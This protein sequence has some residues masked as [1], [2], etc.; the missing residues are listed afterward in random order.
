MAAIV[1]HLRRNGAQSRRQLSDALHLSWGCV[2]ELVF[3]LTSRGVL[4]EETADPGAKGRTPG[5]LALNP[6]FCFLGVEITLKTIRGCV[7][8][9]LGRKVCSYE[10]PSEHGAK[11]ALISCVKTFV[12]GIL[13]THPS[14]QGIGFAMQGIQLG[15]VWEFPSSPRILLSF[16]AD[17][18]PLF[19]LPS[20]M[21]H[22]PNCI[23]YSCLEGTQNRTMVLRLNHGIGATVH[24]PQGFLRDALLELGYYVVNDRGT[25]MQQVA[26]LEALQKVCGEVDPHAP[27]AE[28]RAFLEDMGR[29]VG[30]ALGNLC[31]LL[32]LDEILLCGGMTAYYHLF[33]PTLL[34]HY[35]K[36][37]LPLTR[38]QIIALPVT[39]AAFGAAKMAMDAFGV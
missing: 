3:L 19:N 1:Q 36:T 32:R 29:Y 10:S 23:L 11:E 25:R 4:L 28:A 21:E 15:G 31:N 39:D 33:A 8:D 16:E 13:R 22:D 35:E 7:C 30:T 38:A 27:T 24:T 12:C 34:A 18:Q 20:L 2:S 17:I 14:V 6:R 37:V 26:T 5:L 9:L